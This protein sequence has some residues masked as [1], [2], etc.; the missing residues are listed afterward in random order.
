MPGQYTLDDLH[1]MP[2]Q[3]FEDIVVD[4]VRRLYAKYRFTISKTSYSHDGGRDADGQHIL[5]IGLSPELAI[6]IKVFLEIKKRNKENVG[7]NDIGS[8]LIDAFANKVTKIIF[9]SNRKFTKTLEAWLDQFCGP[10][11]IQ[12]SLVSGRRLL[13]LLATSTGP[14][15]GGN[16]ISTCPAA[17]TGPSSEQATAVH[18]RLTYTLDSNDPVGWSASCTAR[19]DRPVFALVDLK[20]GDKVAPFHGVAAL[21]PKRPGTIVH[22]V[23]GKDT[24]VIFSPGDRQ[25]WIFAIWPERSGLW[26]TGSFEFV[27]GHPDVSLS[28]EVTNTFRMP[29]SG[30]AP[31]LTADQDT[32]EIALRRRLN[33]WNVSGGFALNVL[34]SP[35]GL[36]KSFVVG[37]LRREWQADGMREVV[38]DGEAVGDDVRLVEYTFSKLFPFP[39]EPFVETARPALGRWLESFGLSHQACETLATDLCSGGIQPSRYSTILRTQMFGAL[40]AEASGEHGIVFV[41]ED[42]HKVAP[43]VLAMLADGFSRLA[44]SGRGKVFILLTSRPNKE[45]GTRD[46][47]S[48]W[49]TRLQEIAV[50]SEDAIHLFGP[51]T[52]RDAGEI[53]RGAVPTLEMVHIR[54][55][56]DQVGTTPFNL[57]EA[58]LYLRQLKILQPL[59]IGG[60]AVLVEPGKLRRLLEHDGL[61]EIT[62]NRLMVFFRDK[63]KWL[64][65]LLEA[66]ACYGRQFPLLPVGDAAGAAD[67]HEI[68][69]V[70]A[71][72]AR[73]SILAPSAN[74]RETVEFDHDLVRGAVL[75]LIPDLRRRELTDKLFTALEGN[76]EPMLVAALAYQAGRAQ[77]AFD[78]AR[79]AARQGSEREDGQQTR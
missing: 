58:I 15:A 16:L 10:L 78:S 28:V 2:W 25:R 23:G 66:G 75:S 50:L 30:L 52:E 60:E 61:H 57:R 35:A 33:S 8:H 56:I 64:R 53:L 4:A 7:K 20:V 1:H 13:D 62:R 76:D 26:D 32:T 44:A 40:L 54:Q 21:L 73:W 74:R 18:A 70:I 6:N 45:I 59:E 11:N 17:N 12:Y 51:P 24:P 68:T 3:E 36:G 5:A 22:R 31:I 67:R 38:L 41:L 72:C 47:T 79:R 55:I 49:L 43:S 77:R 65:R 71:D 27:L 19:A 39:K 29:E 63:P 69:D 48:D 46:V 42:L 9:V 37:R 14:S 34:L